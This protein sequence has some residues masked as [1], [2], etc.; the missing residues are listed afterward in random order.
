MTNRLRNV[1]GR[2]M[3]SET[4]PQNR[5]PI[6]LKMEIVTTRAEAVVIATPV[7]SR[8][9]GAATEINAAPAVTFNARMS[10]STYHL[11]LLKASPNLYSRVER[12]VCCCTEGVQPAGA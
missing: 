9:R 3:K 2:P 5:R 1:N 7:K 6:P 11:G 4:Q 10:H 12:T 8:A